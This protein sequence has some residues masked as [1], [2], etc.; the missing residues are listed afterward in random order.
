MTTHGSNQINTPS[1]SNT[2]SAKTYNRP[3]WKRLVLPENLFPSIVGTA[4]ETLSIQGEG[5]EIQPYDKSHQ[6]AFSDSAF[7]KHLGEAFKTYIDAEG[8]HGYVI[9]S[10]SRDL[11]APTVKITYKLSSDMVDNFLII[12]EEGSKLDVY[13]D[14]GANE[15]IGETPIQARQHYGTTRIIAKRGS[16][17]RVIKVQ[18]LGASDNHFDQNFS[19]V[20]E[21]ANLSLVDIQF[22]GKN[23]AVAY[24]SHLIGRHSNTSIESLYF[25]D[26]DEQLDLSFTMKHY[27]TK[28]ESTILSK[29]ALSGNSKKVFRGNL[30]FEKGSVQSVGKEKEVVILLDENVKS[31]SIPA[32]LCS[33]DDVI[34][35]HAASI[36]QLDTDK[37]FYLMS[38]GLSLEASKQLVIKA[39]FEEVLMRL[40]DEALKNSIEEALD[41]RLTSGF[42]L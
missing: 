19:V 31:D 34:G 28:S 27:G 2:L 21:G 9:S 20:E 25:G 41:R 24:E 11:L 32:L 6:E 29:G 1:T 39:S 40:N 30:F 26:S 8:N 22:G 4:V 37:I 33:E 38:R 14:Y 15:A 7:T 18:R 5:V 10:R 36:G 42:K 17:V 16:T 13:I 35:E 12:A 23:K 3:V